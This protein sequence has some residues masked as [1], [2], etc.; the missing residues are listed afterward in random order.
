[1]RI[2][3]V[4]RELYPYVGGGIAPIVAAQARLLS[5]VAEVTIF[6]SAEHLEQH[7]ALAS[8]G[9]E[10]LPPPGVE[11]RFV[12]D[13][14]GEHLGAFLCYMHA[15]SARVHAALR[16][17]YGDHGPDLIEFC[18]YLGEGAVTVQ[19]A[20][21]GARWLRDTCVAVRVHTTSELCAVLNTHLPDD[22]ETLATHDLERYCLRHADRVLWSGGDI[23]DTY[24]RY[25]GAA[26][27]APA[28]RIPD[29][30]FS[31]G[32]PEEQAL[33]DLPG[34]TLRLLYMGRMERRKGVQNLIRAM[35]SLEREDVA[36]TLLGGDT[37]TGPMQTPMRTQLELMAAGDSR[38][39]FM[40]AVPRAEVPALVQ[41][42]DVVIVPSI[43]ECWPNTAREA[44]MLNRPI[45]CTP[46]GGLC[47][48]AQ[49]G[50]S[51]WLT[52][53]N[54][55]NAIARGIEAV[56]D[57]R[58]ELCEMIT[59]EGP[60]EVFRELTD[61]QRLLER[62]TELIVAHGRERAA[63]RVARARAEAPL[64][65]IVVPYFK[66][67]AHIEE[68][69]DS[70]AA[71]T[72][73]AIE[74]I[75]VNDGSLRP[76]DELLWSLVERPGVSLVTQANAG[77]GAARN[78]GITQALGEYILPLDADDLIEPEFV[79][80]CVAALERDPALAFAATWVQ[81]VDEDGVPF[82]GDAGGYVPLGNSLRLIH[83]NNVAG[84]CSALFRR[85]VFDA[86]FRYS[87]DMT[88]YEDW[89]HYRELH[90]AGWY[91]AAIPERLFLYRV[92]GASMTRQVADGAVQQLFDDMRGQLAER[93][94]QW[95]RS[96]GAERAAGE[97]V[98][99]RQ[100]KEG[101]TSAA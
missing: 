88:S 40:D 84:T 43:W 66:L 11:V 75:I 29:G 80:R 100:G 42:H 15:W 78:F 33:G 10:R 28:S 76:Q 81:Y 51:G 45:L 25:Y 61:P 2:A 30:F 69:L 3:F 26:A 63:R 86:G 72:H 70:I 27:I 87:V 64:V 98:T 1:M 39:R 47:E 55:A 94:S 56:A 53:D 48:M 97:L 14:D 96:A 89:L 85:E 34:D 21:T 101:S 77:L 5:A 41:R 54:D 22:F 91:G 82:G 49:P 18:D 36:L 58:D 52:H 50:R 20:Q 83:R 99:T 95:T 6:T 73:P 8:A 44:L 4:S 38:I 90:D 7:E 12:E 79:E 35:T 93:S 74:T 59:R 31:Y 62:Y 65:S 24:R 13:P 46:V 23:L 71:Q 9:D 17:E 57:G 67:E 16:A 32:D 19:A 60:R 68:A 92:R 37:L